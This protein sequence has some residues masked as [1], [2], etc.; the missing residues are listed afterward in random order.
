MLKAILSPPLS[1]VKATAILVG[2]LTEMV[3]I[4]EIKR[5]GEWS[6]HK[7]VNIF[8]VNEKWYLK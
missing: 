4:Y 2:Q 1:F 6:V 5:G 8:I 7:I 3:I